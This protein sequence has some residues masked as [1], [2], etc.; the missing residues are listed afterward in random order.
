MT[1]VLHGLI[2][3]SSMPLRSVET[4]FA[5]DSSGF[6]TNRFE[7]WYDQKYG[8]TRQKAEWVKVHLCCG[9]KTNVVTAAVIGDKNA[10]DC[11]QFPELTNKTATNFTISEM[12]AD[13]A[14]LSADNLALVDVLGG[15]PFVPFKSNSTL[16]NTPLWDRMFHY[17]N[18][19]R[20]KFLAHYHQEKQRRIDLPR[21]EAEV[22]RCRSVKDRHGDDER[23]AGENR[24]PQSDVRNSRMV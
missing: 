12:S 4:D 23:S 17:F 18:M 20:E 10:A 9:T 2:S 15:V 24:L 8:V 14:Y 3:R 21:D 7:R 6:S 1:P 5:V 13:K 11:P 16:G 19:R 22:R